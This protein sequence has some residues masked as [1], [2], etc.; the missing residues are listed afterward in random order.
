MG[1]TTSNNNNNNNENGGSYKRGTTKRRRQQ[2]QKNRQQQQQQENTDGVG[3]V[4]TTTSVTP[5][6]SGVDHSHH[7][8]N[9]NNSSA[10]NNTGNNNT[11]NNN[12]IH[13]FDNDSLMEEIAVWRAASTTPAVARGLPTSEQQYQRQPYQPPPLLPLPPQ[14]QDQMSLS[15]LSTSGTLLLQQQQQ[16][17][18]QNGQVVITNSPYFLSS[19]PISTTTA[20]GDVYGGVADNN[21][22]ACDEHHPSRPVWDSVANWRARR[23]I[24]NTNNNLAEGCGGGDHDTDVPLKGCKDDQDKEAMKKGA[25]SR[26]LVGDK[27]DKNIVVKASEPPHLSSQPQHPPS[28]SSPASPLPPRSTS[29]WGEVANWRDQRRTRRRS[30]NATT[31]TPTQAQTQ[32]P[33]EFIAGGGV[34]GVEVSSPDSITNNENMG[35]NDISVLGE[36]ANWRARRQR[37]NNN[38]DDDN[39]NLSHEGQQAQQ[40][41]RDDHGGLDDDG[42]KMP[43]M[44]E[45]VGIE[46]DDDEEKKNMKKAHAV[47][48][49]EKQLLKQ[50]REMDKKAECI[51]NGQVLFGDKKDG[52]SR[53]S[54][55]KAKISRHIEESSLRRGGNHDDD[56]DDDDE[57]NL[58][59]GNDRRTNAAVR[60]GAYHI[61][62]SFVDNANNNLVLHRS[63]SIAD[64]AE[65]DDESDVNVE[66][67]L[68]VHQ[69]EVTVKPR[70]LASE[71]VL[72]LRDIVFGGGGTGGGICFGFT[73]KMLIIF[74]T[75]AFIV[76][77]II[78]A[79]L[80][81]LEPW[82]NRSK[83][84]KGIVTPLPTVS[85]TTAQPTSHPT[86][87]SPSV[88]PTTSPQPTKDYST[89]LIEGLLSRNVSTAQSLL[90]DRSSP[91]YRAVQWL[92]YRDTYIQD[93]L[94]LGVTDFLLERYV[95][96][97]I[98]FSM[99]PTFL[100]DPPFGHPN[101]RFQDDDK[102]E[103]TF[104]VCEWYGVICSDE[105]GNSSRVSQLDY[106]KYCT[107]MFVD[108]H[109]K[110]NT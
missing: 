36:I 82:E 66:T 110:S 77:G 1:N 100:V 75:Q 28:S 21:I 85:P 51:K 67:V 47:E 45:E 71:S 15:T 96:V 13:A 109:S 99:P 106:C 94:P 53:Y 7:N 16:Q 4:V 37:N 55:I 91:Q 56:D 108:V 23:Q 98:S 92:A 86:S 26:A 89:P 79:I 14:L 27:S 6:N 52:T 20:N 41:E 39:N 32:T 58:E 65:Y 61:R 68:D 31:T 88:S 54:D 95:L 38:N 42:K 60:P 107:E 18:Q 12:N 57:D 8:N 50:Q 17:Q 105:L 9:N 49:D 24:D 11:N 78:I 74:A 43:T 63:P 3:A 102:I 101:T 93:V 35:T 103:E 46:S 97:V 81:V 59:N 69:A 72:I 40:Q 76:I 87:S 80:M 64:D 90:S 29:L 48:C 22:T 84:L 62:P 2:R 44:K 73:L 70:L 25:G 104:D 10:K 19:S 83:E 33:T 34:G 30:R 5:N